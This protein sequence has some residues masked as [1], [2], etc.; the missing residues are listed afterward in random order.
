MTTRSEARV[1]FSIRSV[2]VDA[3]AEDDENVRQLLRKLKKEV[4]K[5]LKSSSRTF[6]LRKKY[7]VECYFFTFYFV[8]FQDISGI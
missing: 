8:P 2:D 4:T 5:Q 3:T 6:P 1:S 7:I